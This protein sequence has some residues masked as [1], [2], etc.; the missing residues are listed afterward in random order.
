MMS[1][2]GAGTLAGVILL[3]DGP[4]DNDNVSAPDE[5]P[6][7]E[8]GG[9]GEDFFATGGGNDTIFGNEA[10]DII[11]AGEDD[12]RVFGGSGG[13]VILGDS[14]DDFLRGGRN[15]D[16]IFGGAGEDVLFG[17]VGNDQLFGADVISA[18]DLVDTLRSGTSKNDLNMNDFVDLDAKTEDADTLDGGYGND[19][20]FAGS[21]DVVIIGNGADTVNV[22][23]WVNPED[24]VR[25][26][27]FDAVEDAIVFTLY[28]DIVMAEAVSED[29]VKFGEDEDG[30]ATL[31]VGKEIFAY[32][33]NTKL[34][35]LQANNTPIVIHDRLS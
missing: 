21:N 5:G 29:F 30:T 14:G 4:D 6:T 19:T 1:F 15:A 24:P 23:Y 35:D 20:I 33:E 13:D 25:I 28:P 34:S 17:D 27:D 31:L 3:S 22:G 9:K 26:T 2:L 11:L 16:L 18:Q 7:R 12:D 32:F 10:N 8:Q